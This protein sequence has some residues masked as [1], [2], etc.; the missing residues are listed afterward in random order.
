MPHSETADARHGNLFF[1]QP[2]G[3]LEGTRGPV[4]RVNTKIRV[5]ILVTV[6]ESTFVLRYVLQYSF[7]GNTKLHI[8]KGFLNQAQFPKPPAF[9]VRSTKSR[10]ARQHMLTHTTSVTLHEKSVQVFF[11]QGFCFAR[12]SLTCALALCRCD[13]TVRVH[14]CQEKSNGRERRWWRLFCH[15]ICGRRG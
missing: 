14:P 15:A 3:M 7:C 2:T 4:K 12:S 9:L 10:D 1:L 8:G 13:F 6:Y 5:L 11:G